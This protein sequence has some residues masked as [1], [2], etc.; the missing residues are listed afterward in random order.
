MLLCERFRLEIP[1]PNERIDRYRPDMLWREQR[2]IVE[3]DGE[4]AHSTPAQILAD[5]RR[6][7]FL[8]QRGFRVVR[9]TYWEVMHRPERVASEVR[10]LPA[11]R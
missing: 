1:E 4:D 7:E 11:W 2:L 5:T 8:E 10:A 3:L 6:Q 9:F